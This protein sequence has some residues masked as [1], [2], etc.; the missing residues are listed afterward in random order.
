MARKSTPSGGPPKLYVVTP[1]EIYDFPFDDTIGYGVDSL[2]DNNIFLL[3]CKCSKCGAPSVQ[4]GSLEDVLHEPREMG[5][6]IYYD[7]ACSA[8]CTNCRAKQQIEFELTV[9]AFSW[10]WQVNAIKGLILSSIDGLEDV[11]RLAKDGMSNETKL[12][13]M[14]AKVDA[15]RFDRERLIREL[16]DQATFVLIVEGRDDL[17]IW[18]QLMLPWKSLTAKVA[19]VKYG[20]GGLSEAVKLARV[21]HDRALRRLPHLLVVDSD[22]D[23]RNTTKKLKS[24][25]LRTDEFH[26]LKKKEIESYLLDPQALSEVVGISKKEA[27]NILASTKGRGKERFDSFFHAVGFPVP[28]EQT[29]ALVARRLN[30]APYELAE[31]IVGIRESVTSA[32]TWM[33]DEPEDVDVED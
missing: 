11:A 24:E 1:D 5:S 33:Q 27:E 8:E 19:L 23:E 12:R 3:G 9:Y 17:A 30:P 16:G 21:F 18:K 29:K 10:L 15:L 32:S 28:D 20:H 22:G 7:G 13:R 2:D 26:V 4:W 25:G 6:E 31:I 14:Q